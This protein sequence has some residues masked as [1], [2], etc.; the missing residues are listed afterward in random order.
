MQVPH[1][2]ILCFGLYTPILSPDYRNCL[3]STAHLQE[4]PPTSVQIKVPRQLLPPVKRESN[5]N[6]LSSAPLSGKG[7]LDLI[8][9]FL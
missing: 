6:L 9:F 2:D 4:K 1:S 8:F 5:L 3:Q 7:T